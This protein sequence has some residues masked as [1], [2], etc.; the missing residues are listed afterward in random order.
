L[1][2]Y[3]STATKSVGK[4]GDGEDGGENRLRGS[5]RYPT[6]PLDR[7]QDKGEYGEEQKRHEGVVEEALPLLLEGLPG[8]S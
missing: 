5:L 2:P 1:V 6:P 7:G 4:S 8:V 3:P